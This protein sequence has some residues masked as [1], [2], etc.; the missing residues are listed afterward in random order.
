[1]Q[2]YI[3]FVFDIETDIGSY[4]K[5]YNGIR[6]GTDKI[7]GLLEKYGIQA[8]FFFTGDAAENNKEIVSEI[9]Q[10]DFEVGC[11]SLKHETVGDA[12]FN[13]PNDSPI[14]EIELENR[15]KMNR[16]IVMAGTRSD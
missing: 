16:E 15:L 3:I 8:T 11:H 6:N 13:M 14:L 12:S 9:A 10:K 7:L 5:T 4:L 1:M 2:K